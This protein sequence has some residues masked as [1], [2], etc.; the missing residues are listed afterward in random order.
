[1]LHLSIS[2][3]HPHV[4]VKSYRVAIVAF[5]I[6]LAVRAAVV[7]FS[8]NTFPMTTFNPVTGVYPFV[9][10]PELPIR[11]S[12][13]LSIHTHFPLAASVPVVV[14]IPAFG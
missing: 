9:A 12:Q 6:T 7:Q 11:T 2:I 5:G 3:T 14:T 13:A 4:V 1:M 8:R 10:A